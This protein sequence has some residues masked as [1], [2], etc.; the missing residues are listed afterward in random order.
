[1]PDLKFLTV[2]GT[3]PNY[4]DPQM[5]L[6]SHLSNNCQAHLPHLV[7][8]ELGGKTLGVALALSCLSVPLKADISLNII[9]GD[10]PIEDV[11]VLLNIL[12]HH[13]NHSG[14]EP[15]VINDLLISTGS[16]LEINAYPSCGHGCISLEIHDV[17]ATADLLQSYFKALPF[18][19][20]SAMEW[21]IGGS[22]LYTWEWQQ[23]FGRLDSSTV[24]ITSLTF[25]GC[26]RPGNFCTFLCSASNIL[27]EADAP[28]QPVNTALLPLPA[29]ETLEFERSD[30]TREACRQSLI[31]A[32]QLR[33]QVGKPLKWLTLAAC[34]I[35][36][37]DDDEWLE[38]LKG[39]VGNFEVEGTYNDD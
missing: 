5:H 3:L 21:H 23:I 12:A 33:K 2:K 29:L 34:L 20:I 1:M 15:V 7:S 8:L 26:F 13:V 35:P 39:M 27:P 11:Q 9:C 17:V 4:L 37:D 32:M 14:T 28:L 16:S 22:T 6:L 18:R 30:F 24:T 31:S 38:T 25:S 36:N 19:P 10:G